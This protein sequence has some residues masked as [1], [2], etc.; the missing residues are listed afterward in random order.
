MV[1][2]RMASV[3]RLVHM[4]EPRSSRE[5]TSFSMVEPGDMAKPRIVY[6]A[7]ETSPPF[8]VDRLQYSINDEYK[9]L[10]KQFLLILG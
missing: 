5:T 4:A 8:I 10:L 6:F 7:N 3:A 2:L 9:A 1:K